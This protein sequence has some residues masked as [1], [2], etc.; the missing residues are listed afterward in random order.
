MPRLSE[1]RDSHDKYRREVSGTKCRHPW[2][3][4]GGIDRPHGIGGCLRRMRLPAKRSS[5]RRGSRPSDVHHYLKIDGRLTG[6]IRRLKRM[7]KRKGLY[8]P[9]PLIALVS[10]SPCSPATSKPLLEMLPREGLKWKYPTLCLFS[11]DF[12]G[13]G[14]SRDFPESGRS[15]ELFCGKALLYRDDFH[16]PVPA[17][18]FDADVRG[19]SLDGQIHRG[20]GHLQVADVDPL[21]RFG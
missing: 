11:Q 2:T 7:D 12:A 1:I 17:F 16:T 14:F 8:L 15:S 13:G 19:E 9:V 5:F 21:E 3:R 6:G 20:V 18:D 10:R 4:T